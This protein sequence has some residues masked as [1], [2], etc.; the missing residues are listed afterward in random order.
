MLCRHL[1]AHNSGI[2]DEDFVEKYEN[3]TGVDISEDQVIKGLG[4]PSEDVYFFAPLK[5][6]GTCIEN[7]EQFIKNLP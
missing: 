5:S 7:C 1:Y 2:L 3:L 4:Y 6:I